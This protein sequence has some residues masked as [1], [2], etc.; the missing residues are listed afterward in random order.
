MPVE[1]PFVKVAKEVASQLLKAPLYVEQSA[2][3]L[4]QLTVDNKLNLTVDLKRPVRGNSAFQ[5]DLCVFEKKGEGI[6][7]PRVVLEFKTHI[8]THDILTYSAKAAKHKQI[9]PY[10][11]YGIIAEKDTEVPK[12]LF[13][14]NDSLDFCAAVSGLDGNNLSDFFS[15]LLSDEVKS[16][17]LL[18]DIAFGSIHTRLFRSEV[19]ISEM[20]AESKSMKR[21]K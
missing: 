18:E 3:L 12:R 11:R 10:L 6:S 8:T 2:A 21:R 16:S 1:S 4:Y 7:I 15:K 9:Y 19:V 17:I 20:S 14:H 5:T 13:T